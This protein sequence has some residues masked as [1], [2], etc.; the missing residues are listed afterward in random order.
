MTFLSLFN[1]IARDKVHATAGDKL[2]AGNAVH[3]PAIYLQACPMQT[4]HLPLSY[5]AP[6][7]VAAQAVLDHKVELLFRGFVHQKLRVCRGVLFPKR[8]QI[9]RRE[10]NER[11][12]F[13]PAHLLN[14]RCNLQNLRRLHLVFEL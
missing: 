3:R 12:P 1:N 4:L 7:K 14:L 10:G 9:L 5:A 13:Q 6:A 2:R 8:Q 11:R